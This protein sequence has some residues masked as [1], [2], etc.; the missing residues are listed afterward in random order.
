MLVL[1]CVIANLQLIHRILDGGFGSSALSPLLEV[2]Q[3]P[4]MLPLACL[5][6]SV[7]T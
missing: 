6:M 7:P 1:T 4:E 2:E 5:E 3:F